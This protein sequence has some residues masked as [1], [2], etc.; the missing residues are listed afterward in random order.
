MS[1]GRLRII[2]VA[3][4]ATSI[5][6]PQP[7]RA[8]VDTIARFGGLGDARGLVSFR[9]YTAAFRGDDVILSQGDGLYVL[10]L[11]QPARRFSARGDGPGDV[12]SVRQMAVVGDSLLTFDLVQR[13]LTVFTDD[14]REASTI[15]FP[16]AAAW[17]EAS[18]LSDGSI[19]AFRAP[20]FEKLMRTPG[21]RGAGVQVRPDSIVVERR[22]PGSD[23]V[24]LGV[25]A[26]SPRYR[27]S[28]GTYFAPGHERVL[29][30][31]AGGHVLM[32]N[33]HSARF[34]VIRPLT[35]ERWTSASSRLERP[36]DPRTHDLLV[37][38]FLN[39][40]RAG[41]GFAPQQTTRDARRA[42][43]EAAGPAAQAPLFDKAVL[44]ES[45]EVWLREG[46]GPQ[47]E[48]WVVV[49]STE[50]ERTVLIPSDLTILAIRANQIIATSR[51]ELDVAT[52]LWLSVVE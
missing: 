48:T 47:V 3:V 10:S 36:M 13:R 16:D 9:P 11:S 8:Q 7:V 50:T 4:I 40:E 5:A 39:E 15:A 29:Q 46:A 31:T 42:V 23:P 32:A 51:D 43:V 30:W 52:I 12:Q 22:T 33:S 44:A 19:V 17:N 24:E 41:L 49:S 35:G 21:Y 27:T 18:P 26:M 14:M 2:A 25:F 37:E 20:D 34:D 1:L 28:D 45:G 6:A 38:Q